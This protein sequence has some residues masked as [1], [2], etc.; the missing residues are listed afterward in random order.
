MR[1]VRTGQIYEHFKK[2]N[3]YEI[4]NVAE[5]VDSAD[6]Y[7]IYKQIPKNDE[8]E[9]D[10]KIWARLFSSFIEDV[11]VDSKKLQRFKLI[12]ETK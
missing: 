8:Q 2:G 11:E 1:N 9:V 6:K 10:G 7:V 5:E 4:L 12:K 3:L